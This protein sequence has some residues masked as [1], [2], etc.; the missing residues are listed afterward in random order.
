MTFRLA[1]G[2]T[3]M[4]NVAFGFVLLFVVAFLCGAV[5]RRYPDSKSVERQAVFG[6][7]WLLCAATAISCGDFWSTNI[8][9]DSYW[10]AAVVGFLVS[11]GIAC[12]GVLSYSGYHK[13]RPKTG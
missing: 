2:D 7:L 8:R 11:L 1:W 4:T 10:L 5:L 3:P 6:I 13:L 12:L 9:P